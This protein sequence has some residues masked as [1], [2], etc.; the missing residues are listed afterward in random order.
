MTNIKIHEQILT[1]NVYQSKQRVKRDLTIQNL[2]A[3]DITN[4]W[5]K[6]VNGNHGFGPDELLVAKVLPKNKS[7]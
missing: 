3:E 4:L 1:H 6:K 2:S 7:C 5:L